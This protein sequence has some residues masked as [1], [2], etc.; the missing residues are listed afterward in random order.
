MKDML[1]QTDATL[2]AC[3]ESARWYQAATLSERISLLQASP[4]A[5]TSPASREQAAQR[6][7]QWQSQAPFQTCAQ[8][9]AQ[10][11][12]LDSLSEAQLETL[13]AQSATEIQHSVPCE[14]AWLRAL[15][16]AFSQQDG[17]PP[18]QLPL[19]R[20]EDARTR[21]MAQAI[22]PL[23][24]GAYARLYRGIA[25]LQA[26]PFDLQ[27]AGLLLLPGIL[28]QLLSR[29]SKTLILELNVARVQER[30]HGATPQQRFADFLQQ[31]ARPGQMLALLEEYP[32]LAR[33]LLEVSERQVT[34]MLELLQRLCADWPEIC[35]LFSPTGDPGVLSAVQAGAGDVHQGGRSVTILTWSSGL[36]LVYK[37]RS[38]AIDAHFQQLLTWLN[39]HGCQPPLRTLRVLPKESYGWCEYIAA[40][41]CTSSEEIERFYQRLGG[42]LAL[43]YTLEATDFHAEN[44]LAAGE[45][46]MLIDLES[47]FQPR[48]DLSEGPA[49]Y[50]R[51]LFRYSVRRVGLLPQRLWSNEKETG[52][53]IS[54]LAGQSGQLTPFTMTTWKEQG[55]DQMRVSR[56][57]VEVKLGNDHR[58]SLQGQ[59]IASSL[60]TTHLITGFRA[61]YRLLLS[62][63]DELLTNMLPR[64]AHDEIR[65]LFRQ[66]QL[67]TMLH[68][69]SFHPNVLRD[70]LERE[71]IF[72]R[73][74]IDVEHQPHL[75][76]LIK[77]ERDDL[78]ANDIPRFTTRPDARDLYTARG[79]VLANFFPE[80]GLNLARTCI[81]HL[82]EH[83]MQRQIWTIRA[84]FASL[85][86]N[87][88]HT[89]PR[90]GLQLLPATESVTRAQLL[91][92]ALRIGG[93]LEQ[94]ALIQQG[95]IG[96]Q[97]LNIVG[98]Q[99]WRPT[100]AGPDLYS[101]LPGIALFLA[102]LGHLSGEGSYTD[103][104]RLTL[105]TLQVL[106]L[107]QKQ[108]WQGC[109]IGAY[110]GAGSLVYLLAHLGSLWREPGLLGE[111]EEVVEIL[112]ESIARDTFF[113]VMSGAA[114][115]I[116]ALLSL[117]AVAPHPPTLQAALQCGDHLLTHARTMPHGLA[118]SPAAEITPL[119]GLSHG[120]A[121]IAL[122]LLRLAAVSREE[123]FQQAAFAALAYERSLFSP[124]KRNWPDLRTFPTS[125]EPE[126]TAR[127]MTAWCHG[128]VGIGLARLAMLPYHDDACVREEIA[129]AVQTTL[130]EGFGKNHSLCHG[131]MSSLEFLAGVA[132]Q[133][134]A[135]CS[136]A[137]IGPLAASLLA[138]M[139]TQGWRSGVP[140]SVETPG[141]MIG[142][143]G[144]G[145]GLL[146]QADPQRLPSLL[147]LDAPLGQQAQ[148]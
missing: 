108:H 29:L 34:H 62:Q 79:E 80:S 99:Q 133:L 53:D 41:P 85:T 38:L 4:P 140:T 31:L 86:L 36:R 54:G 148:V 69:D 107:E 83:D 112:R 28:E 16:Q 137:Q 5:T 96:W 120:S 142:L 61:V 39:A 6:L 81:Q 2:Q 113:D 35:Q 116:A 23:L 17:P 60:Y 141:L 139:H 123:R 78:R 47:L 94:L 14:P 82:D 131:D 101:G 46:P 66:T 90:S 111:A 25:A 45:D 7:K 130:A 22:K 147:L 44:L 52:V 63:R 138:S 87:A 92:E 75:I 65:V 59:E 55:T 64:F 18:Q 77:A 42:Y 143:A 11:L 71:R 122:N 51:M 49:S 115:C 20:L 126:S 110:D 76:R 118:W 70:A 13:L 24:T 106:V 125:A 3:L 27:T 136:Q 134:P 67:Y 84:A 117:Y 33:Q 124:E 10:R 57:R 102:Y 89:P 1:P 73:L 145:Y 9:F 88:A 104:A 26:A 43:L 144:T 109:K 127:F 119:T 56:E 15:F 128:A 146:R 95:L 97:I 100:P 114:G 98:G 48:L 129:I 135:L 93:R 121:G 37:P 40:A 103:L 58:P 30:L 105:H 68:E 8:S 132:Q 12:A 19:H 50:G 72:D 74:W 91:K 32:V 21:A